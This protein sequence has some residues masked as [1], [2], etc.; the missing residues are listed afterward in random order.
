MYY[1]R[2]AKHLPKYQTED[3]V[4]LNA[5]HFST[6]RPSKKLDQK[7]VESYKILDEDGNIAYKLDL[8]PFLTVHPVFHVS[9]LEPFQDGHPGHIQETPTATTVEGEE[10]YEPERV[11]DSRIHD[12]K[13]QVLINGQASPTT[14]TSG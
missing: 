12:G 1:D 11:V 5:R 7:L 6:T 4:W 14:T 13:P 9:V 10:Q 8:P 3:S 2:K